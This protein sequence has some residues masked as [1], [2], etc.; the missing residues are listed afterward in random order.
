M[1]YI[2]PY[3]AFF[4]WPTLLPTLVPTFLNT[5]PV[6]L[7]QRLPGVLQPA[8]RSRFALPRLNVILP[9][10]FL[11]CLTV[12]FNTIV[13]PFTL[14]DNRHYTFYVF[15]LLLRY[16]FT[17]YVVTPLYTLFAWT[18]IGV[19]SCP[20]PISQSPTSEDSHPTSE[21]AAASET[22]AKAKQERRT[23][24][25]PVPPSPPLAH[26][27]ITIP[28]ESNPNATAFSAEGGAHVSFILL[29]LLASTLSLA[30]APLVEP[31]YYILS[32]LIWR[33]HV[34]LPQPQPSRHGGPNRR[35]GW[36]AIRGNN[37]K[38]ALLADG[39]A[40]AALWMETAWMLVVNVL[41]GWVFVTKSFKWES[42]EGLQRFM[43]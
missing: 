36:I 10:L 40:R 21:N 15:R 13:H 39:G 16:R 7:L 27:E 4:S 11:M 1:L 6:T 8:Q 29:L 30:T 18:C 3:M 5:L 33:L 2:W 14:A 35:M 17:K 28:K 37:I 22:T 42:E 19:L 38:R 25:P 12:R 31:R 32:W 9:A 43:W 26:A 23:S 24:L 34:P 41:I 20:L